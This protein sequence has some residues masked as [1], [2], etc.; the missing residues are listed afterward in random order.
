MD[1]SVEHFL[2]GILYV[3]QRYVQRLYIYELVL[4]LLE[5]PANGTF[6]RTT[7]HGFEPISYTCVHSTATSYWCQ[8]LFLPFI[9]ILGPGIA[10]SGVRERLRWLVSSEVRPSV[11]NDLSRTH[12]TWCYR[13]LMGIGEAGYYAGMIYYLSF[14]YKRCVNHA[15]CFS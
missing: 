4:G 15:S 6:F 9:N 8:P 1:A 5:M 7:V 13:V 3:D 11:Q 2:C 14:W 12:L 10:V